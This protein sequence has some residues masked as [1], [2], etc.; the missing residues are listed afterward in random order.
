MPGYIFVTRSAVQ[1]TEFY[2]NLT[3]DFDSTDA[4][5]C[6]HF[7]YVMSPVRQC[8]RNERDVGNVDRSIAFQ[9]SAAKIL[10]ANKGD[11]KSVFG[12][13]TR[14]SANRPMP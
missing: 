2:V 12:G 5:R 8:F 14:A 10:R 6:R 4:I 11:Y 13:S 7:N 1:A 3:Y 9:K